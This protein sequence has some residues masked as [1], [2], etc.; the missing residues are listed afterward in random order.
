MT[1]VG[2]FWTSSDTSMSLKTYLFNLRV[3]SKSQNYPR[4]IDER[5]IGSLMVRVSSRNT[6]ASL[7]DVHTLRNTCRVYRTQWEIKSHLSTMTRW[8]TSWSH[9]T[10]MATKRFSVKNTSMTISPLGRIG[11]LRWWHSDW[12]MWLDHLMSRSGCGSMSPGSKASW[13]WRPGWMEGRARSLVGRRS[14]MRCQ[15]TLRGSL[16]WLTP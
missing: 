1:R 2:S 3:K 8:E 5:C 4:A 12:L 7:K 16:A 10:H 14:G 11:A 13:A 6:E 15:G 9:W